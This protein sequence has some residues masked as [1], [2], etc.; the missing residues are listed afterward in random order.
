MGVP[1]L[2]YPIEAPVSWRSL[3]LFDIGRSERSKAKKTFSSY[4]PYAVM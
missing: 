2:F 3:I 4:T 1:R